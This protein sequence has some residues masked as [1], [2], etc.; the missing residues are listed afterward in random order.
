MPGNQLPAVEHIVHLMLENRSFDHLLGFRYA[1]S[2]NV[3]PAGAAFEGLTGRESNPDSSGN[4]V[5]IFKISS[6]DP[7]AC[8]MPGACPGEGYAVS[9]LQQIDAQLTAQL[10]VPAEQ[11]RSAPVLPAMR[12]PADYD[13]Y[14]RSRTAIW[15]GARGRTAPG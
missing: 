2:G 3:S 11:L 13:E 8:Y 15:K 1:D 5:T 4:P 10:P 7:G 12:T 14:T 6:T 9:H